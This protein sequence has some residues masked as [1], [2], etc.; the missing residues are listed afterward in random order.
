MIRSG[1]RVGVTDHIESVVSAV[2]LVAL[3]LGVTVGM[4][5]ARLAGFGCSP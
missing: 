2:A 4:A 3:L 1:D 5:I